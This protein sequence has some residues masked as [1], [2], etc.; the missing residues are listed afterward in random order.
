MISD[1]SPKTIFWKQLS[2]FG[3]TMGT[4][5]EFLS[6]LDYI[7]KHQLKPIIDS[8]YPLENITEAFKRMEQGE[9]FGKIVLSIS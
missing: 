9:Q 3:S 8:S 6:M 7:Y 2:I 4:E 1:T 5:D